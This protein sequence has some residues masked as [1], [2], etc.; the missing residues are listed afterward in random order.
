VSINYEKAREAVLIV[1]KGTPDEKLEG[2]RVIGETVIELRK[3][4]GIGEKGG[5]G[6]TESNSDYA[7]D[8]E[9]CGLDVFAVRLRNDAACYAE[10]SADF[11]TA[12]AVLKTHLATLP[13]DHADAVAITK[14]LGWASVGRANKIINGYAEDGLN[15]AMVRIRKEVTMSKKGAHERAPVG[16]EGDPEVKMLSDGK[17]DSSRFAAF[18]EEFR[19][20]MMRLK[21]LKPAE[22][23][24]L[25]AAFTGASNTVGRKVEVDGETITCWS[26]P[27][28]KK[29]GK[30]ATFKLIVS[31]VENE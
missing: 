31:F 23:K 9:L 3:K 25:L 15:G 11:S 28:G 22:R 7:K 19:N 8:I 17:P 29:G 20:M 18:G 12:R 16:T 14:A 6:K 10:K 27:V 21:K 5:G 1:G 26:E 4:H 2:W 30:I 24:R 13:E